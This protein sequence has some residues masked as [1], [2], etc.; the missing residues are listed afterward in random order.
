MSDRSK[1]AASKFKSGNNCAQAVL[2][3]FSDLLEQDE[4]E[5][6][7]ITAALGGGMGKMQLTCGAVTGA[8]LALSIYASRKTN[9]ND[10]AKALSGELVREFSKKFTDKQGSLSCREIT[11]VDM[12]TEEGKKEIEEKQIHATICSSAVEDA[13]LIL[14]GMLT[15][16]LRD[17]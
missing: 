4:K 3:S 7:A 5:L 13:V 2:T 6:L 8:F 16:E 15:K 14:E 12:N 9:G 17:A 11:G 10:G 1:S